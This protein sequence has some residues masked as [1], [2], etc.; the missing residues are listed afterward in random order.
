MSHSK[1]FELDPEEIVIS[2][3]AYDHMVYVVTSKRIFRMGPASLVHVPFVKEEPA[4]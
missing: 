3:Q 1:P 2:M 4:Q